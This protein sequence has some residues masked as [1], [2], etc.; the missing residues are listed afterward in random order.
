MSQLEFIRYTSLSVVEFAHL[1]P[2]MIL[3]LGGLVMIGLELVLSR[4]ST[5]Q[6]EWLKRGV[7]AFFFVDAVLV[8]ALLFPQL[9]LDLSLFGG[10][11][12]ISSFTHFST[13][14][15]GVMGLT[16]V[17]L[18]TPFHTDKSHGGEYYSL[19]F[20]GIVGMSLMV[21]ANDLILLFVALELMSLSIYVLISSKHDRPIFAEGS[22]KYFLLGAFSS[23]FFL[24]GIA[25][26]YGAYGT[27]NFDEILEAQA[28][29]HP[30]LFSLGLILLCSG[31]F[32]KFGLVPFHMYIPDAY[33]AAPS[34][35]TQ[36]MAVGVKTA[37]FLAGLRVI[38]T[39]FNHDPMM[40]HALLYPVVVLSVLG[41]NL[42]AI[43]Q[44]NIKRML[45]YSSIAHAGYLSVALLALTFP[46][47]AVRTDAV[48]SIL[49]Y[50]V[51]YGLATIGLFALLVALEQHSGNDQLE[52]D[53]VRGLAQTQPLVSVLFLILLISI[54]GL[55]ISAGFVGKYLVF[56]SAIRAGEV[57][58]TVIAIIGSMISLYYYF[59]IPINAYLLG[60]SEDPAYRWTQPPMS[61]FSW[62]MGVALVCAA[63]SLVLGIIPQGWL[64]VAARAVFH[65][66]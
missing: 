54:S 41:A 36:Y 66:L 31:L 12:E 6:F 38:L 58:I 20:F 37:I 46:A 14:V 7:A 45:A 63:V 44:Q 5:D 25:L 11:I 62:P 22:L 61:N 49:V 52:F 21:H 3:T 59:R 26:M 35:V 39:V 30:A 60:P 56:L 43:K 64:Q 19:L 1:L 18:G 16:T 32:F 4:Q 17:L 65:G 10:M 42:L 9:A 40:L 33:Q 57:G 29:L 50:L 13:V 8:A 48:A 24:M 34:Q 27:T 2:V 23:G 51:A 47:S 53:H 28:S 15:F 55:P